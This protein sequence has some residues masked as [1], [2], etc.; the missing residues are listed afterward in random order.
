LQETSLLVYGVTLLSKIQLLRVTEKREH[1]I[2]DG[3]PLILWDTISLEPLIA[4]STAPQAIKSER[5]VR[6]LTQN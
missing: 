6:L 1:Q 4:P 2:A 5:L 3:V